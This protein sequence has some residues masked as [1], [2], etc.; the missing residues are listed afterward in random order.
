MPLTIEFLSPDNAQG[1]IH[2]DRDNLIFQFTSTSDSGPDRDDAVKKIHEM[3]RILTTHA[4]ETLLHNKT[5]SMDTT[6]SEAHHLATDHISSFDKDNYHLHIKFKQDIDWEVTRQI[7]ESIPADALPPCIKSE[8]KDHILATAYGYFH[9]LAN[10]KQAQRAERDHREYKEQERVAVIES[11]LAEASNIIAKLDSDLA[12]IK[13]AL[14]SSASK[15]E[16]EGPSFYR[17]DNLR[18]LSFTETSDINFFAKKQITTLVKERKESLM[19]DAFK[20]MPKPK[21]SMTAIKDKEPTVT[22]MTESTDEIKTL[23]CYNNLN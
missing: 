6:I 7:F 4:K 11:E 19:R 22:L 9:E 13:S 20:L 18:P 1:Y 14:T 12:I 10:N 2:I 16:N 17:L 5:K 15:I 8:Y 23:A 3:N 21:T